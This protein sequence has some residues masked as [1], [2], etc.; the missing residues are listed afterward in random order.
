MRAL[1]PQPADDVDVMEAYAPPARAGRTRYVRCNMISTFDGAITLN[2]RSGAL[3]GRADRRVFQVLRSWA[4]VVVV[5]AGTARAERYGPARL[6]GSLRAA[7]AGRGQ[8]PV[9]PIAVVTSSGNL[10]IGSS[11]FTEAEVRPIVVTAGPGEAALRARAGTAGGA[12]LADLADVLVAGDKEVDMASAFDTLAR[13]G[14]GS[15]LVEGGPG[16]NADIVRA[17]L[18]DELCLTV[19]PRLVAGDGPRVVAGATLDPPLGVEVVR[20]ME[21]DG[22]LFFRLAVA[23]ERQAAP[24]GP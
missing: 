17:G 6:D 1:L 23:A 24:G 20:L 13:I 12:A 16:L 4:D 15:L 10:D 3:G 8:P 7:R 18:L 11:F 21:E 2:G 19:S 5:G 9:P 14:S 22:F